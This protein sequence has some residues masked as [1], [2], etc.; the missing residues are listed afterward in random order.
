M[1][2]SKKK[3]KEKNILF[4]ITNQG[5]KFLLNLL[6]RGNSKPARTIA[7]TPRFGVF[8]AG[9]REKVIGY[10]AKTPDTNSEE[11]TNMFKFLTKAQAGQII[12]YHGTRTTAVEVL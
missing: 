8:S 9:E 7:G 2:R 12:R 1:K 10:V 3:R 5:G 4:V 11:L 6:M